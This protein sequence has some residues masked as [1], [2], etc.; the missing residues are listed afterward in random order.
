MKKLIPFI[1]SIFLLFLVFQNV[2][3]PQ[4]WQTFQSIQPGYL[5][6]S[7]ACIF[8]SL[9]LKFWRW[10]ALLV[11][12]EQSI[13]AW[14]IF[15]SMSLGILMDLI[16]PGKVGELLRAHLVGS[17]TDLSRSKIFGTIVLERLFD[18]STVIAISAIAIPFF[19]LK[20]NLLAES[21][22]LSGFILGGLISFLALFLFARSRLY[23]LIHYFLPE[24]IS[25]KVVPLLENLSQGVLSVSHWR[26][27]LLALAGTILMWSS[28][29]VGFMLLLFAVPFEPPAPYYTAFVLLLLTAIGVA[30][31]TVPGGMGIYEY[32]AFLALSITMPVAV[33]P[34]HAEIAVFA[35]LFHLVQIGPE[36]IIGFY[37]LQREYRGLSWQEAFTR[38]KSIGK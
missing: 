21:L 8:L 20:N 1:I 29:I 16:L 24:K 11:A 5:F 31:P 28:Y 35:I 4:F 15:S 6:L 25:E 7:I 38:M 14:P 33:E 19:G 12:I 3:L 2:D 26:Q 10:R 18:L 17:K 32:A 13:R 34:M 9:F 23:S 30:L 27:S 37:C 36:L 22:V